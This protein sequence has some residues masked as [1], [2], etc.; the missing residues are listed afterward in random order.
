MFFNGHDPIIR[1]LLGVNAAEYAATA[2]LTYANNRLI[3]RLTNQYNSALQNVW[4]T[5]EPIVGDDAW[6]LDD[7]AVL[8]KYT[9][10]VFL[11]ISGDMRVAYL[12]MSY[13]SHGT[14]SLRK[15]QPVADK[16][17]RKGLYI[18]LRKR[19]SMLPIPPSSSN[20]TPWPAKRDS[21]K[22]PATT[23]LRSV[24]Y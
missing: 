11:R 5:D 7:I 1:L 3:L 4:Q 18:K 19:S 14:I 22:S 9:G 13:H 6:V 23:L 16:V 12:N 20:G 8:Q 17:E 24:A 10:T 2:H 15:Q 21:I